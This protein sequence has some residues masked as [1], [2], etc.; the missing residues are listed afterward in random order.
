MMQ[1]WSPKIVRKIGRSCHRV[2]YLQCSGKEEV[3][4]HRELEVSFHWTGAGF[5]CTMA[6]HCVVPRSKL[7]P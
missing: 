7:C 2:K 3:L 4:Q 1:G 6:L 5:R